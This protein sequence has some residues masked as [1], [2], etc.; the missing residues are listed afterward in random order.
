MVSEM[1]DYILIPFFASCTREWDVCLQYIVSLKCNKQ[2]SKITR[3]LRSLWLEP[4][5]FDY[6]VNALELSRVALR[7][8][9]THA[10]P[11]PTSFNYFYWLSSN[12]I[13]QDTRFIVTYM[14]KPYIKN[15]IIEIKWN[16]ASGAWIGNFS[17]FARNLEFWGSMN[18]KI[19]IQ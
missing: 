2:F 10:L 15:K 7:I 3:L 17:C 14:V 5:P 19:C 13:N 9:Y 4:D 16:I 18:V 11:C 1:R 8:C 12:L 6:D